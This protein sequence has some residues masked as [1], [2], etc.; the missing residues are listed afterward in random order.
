MGKSNM[1]KVAQTFMHLGKDVSTVDELAIVMSIELKLA[2]PSEAKKIIG[3]AINSGYLIQRGDFVRTTEDLARLS[4]RYE[5]RNGKRPYSDKEQLRI[6]RR[7]KSWMD[8]DY[9]PQPTDDFDD[10]QN[11]D[12]YSE[13]FWTDYY[14]LPPGSGRPMTK[15]EQLQFYDSFKGWDN[16]DVSFYAYPDD[17]MAGLDAYDAPS[18]KQKYRRK[19]TKIGKRFMMLPDDGHGNVPSE[20]IM[21]VQAKRSQKSRLMDGR[22]RTATVFPNPPSR[23]DAARWISRPNKFDIEGVDAPVRSK[24]RKA[25]FSIRPKKE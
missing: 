24:N 20:Y 4:M 10:P 18:A 3:E 17:D 6:F 22:K 8:D 7:T 14:G 21:E 11:L 12:D 2:R 9:H 23:K 16:D 19:K 25:R 1:K 13:D 5:A 15:K